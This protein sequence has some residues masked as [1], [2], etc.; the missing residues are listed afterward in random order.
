MSPRTRVVLVVA[1]LAA[2]AAASTVAATVL[3]WGGDSHAARQSVGLR[4]GSPPFVLDELGLRADPEAQRLRRA[5]RLYGRGD[6][7]T[8][9]RLLAGDGSL[10]ARVGAALAGWPRGTITELDGL[11][12][13]H[14]RSAFV[15]LHLGLALAWARR[16][17]EARQ[18]WRAAERV[19]PSSPSA[20]RAETLLHPE[21]APGRPV[22][23]PT[24]EPPASLARRSPQA[25]LAA[26]ARAARRPD[27][28]AKVL[29]GVALQ[30]LE[31]PVSAERQYAAA[32]AL[33]SRDPEARVAAAVGLFDKE[34]P[35]LAFSRLGPLSRTFPRAQSVRFHLG[36]LLLW[37]GQVQT[38]KKELRLARAEGP[39]TLLGSQANA[40]LGRL[41]R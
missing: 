18:A 22:F 35:A 25:Q 41:G 16:D 11:S 9:G 30:R 15:R 38:A 23:V 24:F 3:I 1:V 34:R 20:V 8:A 4:P 33:A 37:I 14:P 19:G 17:A 28:R 29:Y 5:E 12:R 21:F 13:A 7:A 26:L 32:A 40:L 36:L 39:K 31:R 2:A 10:G 6:R 27:W